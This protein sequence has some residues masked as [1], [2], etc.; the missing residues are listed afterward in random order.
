MGSHEGK[1]EA[2]PDHLWWVA[3][4]W[5]T[6][7][8][9]NLCKSSPLCGTSWNFP[10]VF[11][12]HVSLLQPI[13]HLR[14]KGGR[15]WRRAEGRKRNTNT[16]PIFYALYKGVRAGDAATEL[17][18][19]SQQE[20]GEREKAIGQRCWGVQ[21]G[22]KEATGYLWMKPLFYELESEKSISGA[23]TFKAAGV[24]IPPICLGSSLISISLHAVLI[25]GQAWSRSTR[26]QYQNLLRQPR[27]SK[28]YMTV[29]HWRLCLIN[30]PNCFV[31]NL[32]QD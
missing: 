6:A 20:Q 31:L 26:T 2:C 3:A 7:L 19:A 4:E 12:F 21:L 1:L 8:L 18:K 29:S 9:G 11:I 13:H 15:A 5:L 10:S 17:Q 25:D 22:S 24:E 16:Q 23:I 30:L 32:I 14:R 28:A 27:V